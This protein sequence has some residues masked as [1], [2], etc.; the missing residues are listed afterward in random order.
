VK[1][2][3]VNVLPGLSGAL[4]KTG[5]RLAHD[6]EEQRHVEHVLQK[7]VPGQLA[8]DSCTEF[9]YP[10]LPGTILETMPPIIVGSCSWAMR[11]SV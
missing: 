7:R 1:T 9:A 2:G 10:F 4:W 8:P 5:V 6:M 11:S 3:D